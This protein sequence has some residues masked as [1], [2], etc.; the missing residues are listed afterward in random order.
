MCSVIIKAI[1]SKFFFN[2]VNVLIFAIIYY[3]SLKFNKTLNLFFDYYFK[4]I[5]TEY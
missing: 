3:K 1:Y 4:N 2:I 5:R